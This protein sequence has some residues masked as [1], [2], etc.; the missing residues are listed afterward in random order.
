MDW[1][2]SML[3]RV[4]PSHNM[5]RYWSARVQLSLLEEV[6]LVQS[7][8]RICSHGQ[9]RSYQF[10]TQQAALSA[11]TK[12]TAVKRRRG[13]TEMEPRQ[14][15]LSRGRLFEGAGTA[16]GANGNQQARASGAWRSA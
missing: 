16:H 4:D 12:I 2:A 10:A 8:G 9:E 1:P 11:F 15:G 14:P 13:Y 5:P 6:L 3:R 7:W